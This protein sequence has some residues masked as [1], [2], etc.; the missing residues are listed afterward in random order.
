MAKA[1]KNSNKDTKSKKAISKAEAIKKLRKLWIED[2]GVFVED[3]LGHY[4]THKSPKFHEE[5]YKILSNSNRVVVA[6]PR[7]FAKSMLCSVFYVIHEAAFGLKRDITIISASE[8]L[9]VEWVRKIR[10]ELEANP[11][12]LKF[13]GDLRSDKWTESHLIL[14]NGVNIRAK[15]AG[16]QIRG[17]RPDL[18]ILDDIETDE[19]VI[20]EEQRNKL[21]DW[22]FRACLNTLLPHGQFIMIG[23]I[24]SQLS[25]LQEILDT[26]N[27]WEKRVYQAYIGGE[28]A[29]GKELWPQLWPHKKLQQ[30]KAEIGSFAFSSEYMNNPISN[31]T[32]PIK[33]YQIRYWEELPKQYSAVIA[34]DPAY[35]DD[36][37]A[38]Y[39]VAVLVGI[40]NNG[41]R[42][43]INYLR[44]HRPTG[45]FIDGILNM[46]LQNK[47]VI[48]GVGIPNSGVEKEFFKSAQRKAEE[49]RVY[50]PFVEVKNAFTDSTG[51][52]H[53]KKISRI[54][55]ALQPLFEAGKYYIH[56]NHT[57]AKEEL[58][59][60]GAAKHEDLADALTYAES[61]I[62]PVYF[63]PKE[64]NIGRY[65]ELLPEEQPS[66]VYNYG[67]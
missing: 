10:R 21:R 42:Y 36:E 2:I 26:D 19:S 13:F 67:Y 3:I 40:D 52:T 17:F 38:D 25:I 12:I 1:S 30:R 8:G 4:L 15:G 6:A 60:L 64:E 14:K 39:K 29:E 28:Q 32:A 66:L 24:I 44:T 58:L 9:A 18:I 62:Q 41:N 56:K 43:L 23:T 63:E 48:T 27:G 54:I 55:A 57:E 45:E 61:I 20:S 53:R 34:V 49:R 35:S 37:R 11:V 59:S 31:E 16:A 51:V 47:G 22:I 33:P 65:G 46:Y 5:I 7:G 50:P